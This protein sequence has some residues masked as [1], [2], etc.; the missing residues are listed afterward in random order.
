MKITTWILASLCFTIFVL[1]IPTESRATV[2]F[3]STIALQVPN[4]TVTNPTYVV[5][6]TV[7]FALA[8][9]NTGN[10]SAN[11]GL[12]VQF[13][14]GQFT[15]VTGTGGSFSCSGG[16]SLSCSSSTPLTP[17]TPRTITVTARTPSTVTGDSQTFTV[18]ATIDPTKA[19][20]ETNEGNNQSTTTTTVVPKGQDLTIDLTGSDATSVGL[21]E[22]RYK[23]SIKNIGDRS[24]STFPTIVAT[25]P[26]A[27]HYLRI[28]NSEFTACN[29]SNGT[30]HCSV[31][32]ALAAGATESAQ[33]VGKVDDHVANNAVV[34]F[35]A[36]ADPP[37]VIHESDE[38]NNNSSF[39]TTLTEIA[40]LFVTGVTH[41]FFSCD[42]NG[43]LVP[44]STYATITANVRNDGHTTSEATKV[45]MEVF[46]GDTSNHT[47]DCGSHKQKVNCN[48]NCSGAIASICTS[49]NSG[50]TCDINSLAPNGVQQLVITVLH[51]SGSTYTTT[52]TVDP[53]FKVS[54]SNE[55]NNVTNH[56]VH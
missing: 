50:A 34:T 28:E 21:A 20:S 14:G 3:S 41:S 26:S 43:D 56:T 39:N 32:N 53:E 30:I 54:E 19:V 24:T 55:D 5:G 37:N 16:T 31:G 23:V 2:D 42:E 15:Q 46:S 11:T 35:T 1:A 25:L 44:E 27:V 8:V 36:K 49:T 52:F 48:F 47:F 33:I 38:A 29:H 17:N 51:Q 4:K 6:S 12:T 18:T 40:D 7:S 9:K 13:G 45:K 10:T 22:I